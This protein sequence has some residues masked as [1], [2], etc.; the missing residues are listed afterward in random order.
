MAP[1][2]LRHKSRPQV[3]KYEEYSDAKTRESK[4]LR[5]TVE[6]RTMSDSKAVIDNV[7]KTAV[8]GR[9]L[10][11]SLE[12]SDVSEIRKQLWD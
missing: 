3:S 4:A 6:A 8:T 5:A 1:L 7:V 9:A 11:V 12:T 10:L 2:H